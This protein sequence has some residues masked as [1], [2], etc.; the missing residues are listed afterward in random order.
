MHVHGV[1]QNTDLLWLQAGR[2]KTGFVDGHVHNISKE[3]FFVHALCVD[4]VVHLHTGVQRMAGHQQWH[5][6]DLFSD[7][8]ENYF[9]IYQSA[10]K[11]GWKCKWQSV[12]VLR[13]EVVP[14]ISELPQN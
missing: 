12:W 9:D 7:D 8:L 2:E 11:H 10:K 13:L 5:P 6:V 3:P 14:T 1:E 4:Q